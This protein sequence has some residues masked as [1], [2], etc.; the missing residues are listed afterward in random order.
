[1]DSSEAK[2]ATLPR[3]NWADLQQNCFKATVILP[4]NYLEYF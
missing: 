3:R 2:L 4:R 1:M